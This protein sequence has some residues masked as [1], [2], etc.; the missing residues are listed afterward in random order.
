[1]KSPRSW[2]LD[3][4]SVV[5]VAVVLLGGPSLAAA[6]VVWTPD[7]AFK[8]K[9][10]SQVAASP[11]GKRVAYV[12][13]TAEMEGE[14]SEWLSQIHVASADGTSDLQLTRGEKSSS[15]P[16]WS[17]DGQWVAFVSA[18][19]GKPQVWRIPIGGG[20]AEQ[21]TDE[22]S[23]PAGPRYS[24]DGK[25]IAFLMAEAKTEEEEKADK[26]KRDFRVIGE[27]DKRTRLN[28]V[29][30]EKDAAGKRPVKALSPAGANIG[31]GDGSG[32]YDWSPD[33]RQIAFAHQPSPLAD[34]WTRQDVSV[35]DVESG[36]VRALAATAA[37]ESSPFFSPD[38]AQVAFVATDVPPTWATAA[39][40]YVVAA[41][42]GTPRPLA[43]TFDRQPNLAGFSRD[44]SRLFFTETRCTVNR[45]AALPLDGGPPVDL[46]RA[47]R[48]VDGASVNLSG[49]H[50]AFTSQAADRAPE[51]FV[52]A[53]DRPDDAVQVSH[54]QEL[55]E[56]DLGKTD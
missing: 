56:G 36:T 12:V 10:V 43:E 23:A 21:L 3:R 38:G 41:G 54:A 53:L 40:V 42:G 24:P 50:L 17:P 48:M 47:D 4:V 14:K 8:V 51:A 49:T 26:E 16:A 18:R 2:S 19:G 11:D 20:E 28:V 9:R 37:A 27:G 32:D 46:G 7:L 30:V 35:V 31:D 13:A 1:M 22:K 5:S 44:G 45:L 15:A 6:P 34:D 39:R 52:A 25:H 55:P 29:P 33:S